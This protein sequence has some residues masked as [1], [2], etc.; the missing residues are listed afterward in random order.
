MIQSLAVAV[1]VM[2]ALLYVG[3]RYL[4][5]GWRT[6][7]VYRLSR[8]NG[9]R[10]SKLVQ[11]LDTASSCG[12]GGCDSCKACADPEPVESPTGH[13]VIKVHERH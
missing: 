7:L 8:R 6:R 4:P 2:L 1:I 3:A 12:S 9:Q 11:W 10:Q 13:R 5:K